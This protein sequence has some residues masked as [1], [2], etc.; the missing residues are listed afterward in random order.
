VVENKRPRLPPSYGW[1][2]VGPGYTVGPIGEKLTMHG[3]SNQN[4]HNQDMRV[5]AEDTGARAVGQLSQSESRE[6]QGL[7]GA[8]K[9]TKP[10]GRC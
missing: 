1:E 8:P 9:D 2:I 3:R 5:K 4:W 7:R 10:R 6:R